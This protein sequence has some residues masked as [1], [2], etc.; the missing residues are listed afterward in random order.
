MVLILD[1]VEDHLEISAAKQLEELHLQRLCILL[2]LLKEQPS[3]GVNF[4]NTALTFEDVTTG[5][6][7][8]IQTPTPSASV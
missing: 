7:S 8:F 3:A 4:N 1:Q 6:S 5:E 2:Q